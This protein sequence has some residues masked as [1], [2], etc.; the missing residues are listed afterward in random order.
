MCET[1]IVPED[2]GVSK[3]VLTDFAKRAVAEYRQV[4]ADDIFD[5]LCDIFRYFDVEHF[6]FIDRGVRSLLRDNLMDKT[7]IPMT[8][9]ADIEFRC[10]LRPFWR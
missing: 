8:T 5:L 10:H 2:S 9:V 4:A 3:K 6:E 7:K 1:L